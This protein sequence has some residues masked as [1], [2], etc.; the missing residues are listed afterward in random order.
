MIELHLSPPQRTT[1]G[2]SC[3]LDRSTSDTLFP[4]QTEGAF[5]RFLQH[6][7]DNQSNRR[8]TKLCRRPPES[9]VF[10]NTD[11]YLAYAQHRHDPHPSAALTEP[12]MRRCR[13]LG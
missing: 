1:F 9:M 8:E 6:V 10:A 12:E 7:F 13:M 5:L 11:I 4:D 2:R 3:C